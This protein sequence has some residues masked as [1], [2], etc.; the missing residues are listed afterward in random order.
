MGGLTFLTCKG[1]PSPLRTCC[2]RDIDRV[3]LILLN[4]CIG[5]LLPSYRLSTFSFNI[6]YI[7]YLA[8]WS[9]SLQL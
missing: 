4:P 3:Y 6:K 5:S 9:L 2:S 7:G 1:L 8:V